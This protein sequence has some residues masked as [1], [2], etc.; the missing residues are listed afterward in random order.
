MLIVEMYS[1]IHSERVHDLK[2]YP[3]VWM[4][5]YTYLRCVSPPNPHACTLHPPS[6]KYPLWMHL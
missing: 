6:R 4:A 2:A 1:N 5:G 3:V